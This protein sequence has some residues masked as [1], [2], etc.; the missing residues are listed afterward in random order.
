MVAGALGDGTISQD[1]VRGGVSC[2]LVHLGSL[3]HDD[4][5]DESP[6]RRGV[7]TVNA[8]GETCKRFLPETFCSLGPRKSQHLLALKS[9]PSWPRPLHG[10]VK[11]RSKNFEPPTTRHERMRATLRRSEARQPRCTERQRK[12]VELSPALTGQ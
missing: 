11:D 12:S 1:V 4:V 9:L 2:E 8:S 10:Y 6:T 7:E 3:Y 5:M